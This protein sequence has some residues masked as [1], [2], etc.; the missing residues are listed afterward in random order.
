MTSRDRILKAFWHRSRKTFVPLL[1]R[2]IE[3][4]VRPIAPHDLRSAIHHLVTGGLIKG[5]RTND[6][7]DGFAY[8]V[9]EA[10]R[11]EVAKIVGRV[12]A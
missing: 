6:N 5:A 9:T 4:R 8:E 11:E 1:T 10:G 7:V 3:A 2:E 12:A